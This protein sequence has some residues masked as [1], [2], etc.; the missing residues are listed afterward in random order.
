M[1]IVLVG[2]IP[3][4]KNSRRIVRDFRVIPSKLYVDWEDDAMYQLIEQGIPKSKLSGVSITYQLYA[5]TK[6][7]KDASNTIESIND[8]LVKYGVLEDDSWFH[9]KEMHILPV[10][11]DKI[12]GAEITLQ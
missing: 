5:K 8:L 11:V 2:N 6:A 10:I 7:R 12:G 1:K 9:I 3:P 4:K